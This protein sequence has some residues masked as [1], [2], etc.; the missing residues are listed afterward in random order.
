MKKILVALALFA[1]VL[2]ASAL[3]IDTTVSDHCVLLQNA[4]NTVKGKAVASSTVTVTLG[5]TQIGSGTA[6]GSGN[7]TVTVNPGAASFA[8]RSLVVTDGSDTK[9][10]ADVLVGEVWLGAGQ[11]NAFNPMDPTKMPEY[12]G[13]YDKWKTYFDCPNVR[14]VVHSPD[15]ADSPDA[16]LAWIV[17]KKGNET[18][19][20]K[21]S[22]LALF[23]ARE[24]YLAKNVPVGVAIV[25]RGANA[26]GRFMSPEAYAAAKAAR[27]GGD[28]PWGW[29]SESD[30]SNFHK[31]LTRFDSVAARGCVWSQGEAEAIVGGAYGYRHCLKALIND[32]RS[33]AHRNN[34]NFPVIIS[35]TANY[36]GTYNGDSDQWHGN[37]EGEYRSSTTRW[38]QE[39]AA[40]EMSNVV[41]V[42]AIDLANNATKGY[43]RAEHPTQKPE[44]AARCCK[45]ARS[46][47][48]GENVAYRCPYPT[49]A[50]FN[51][52][53]DKVYVSFPS[54]VSLTMKGSYTHIPFRVKNAGIQ[55]NGSA[56]N[57]TSVKIGSDGHTLEI[58]FSGLT[59]NASEGNNAVAYCNVSGT[60]DTTPLYEQIIYDQN[61]FPL[62]PFELTIANS[63]TESKDGT[64]KRTAKFSS[65]L[66]TQTKN[67]VISK[68]GSG[69][70]PGG[71]T[72]S[73]KANGYEYVQL[74]ANGPAFAK[75]NVG[76]TSETE[77]GLM[78]S[79][80][81][82]VGTVK[83]KT[84]SFDDGCPT[85]GKS[86]AQLKSSDIIDS[87]A[88]LS[89]SYDAANVKMGGDWRMPTKAEIDALISN[90]N[91]EYVTVNDVRGTRVTGRGAYASASIFLPCCGFYNGGGAWCNEQFWGLYLTSTAESANNKVYVYALQANVPFSTTT[92]NRA[93]GY[94]I[95]GV[96]QGATGSGSGKSGG[97]GGD[98]KPGGDSPVTTHTNKV[99][100][101]KTGSGSSSGTGSAGG[102]KGVQLWANGPYW[103]TMNCGATTPTKAGYYY[104][105][106]TDTVGYSV[107]NGALKGPLV[108]NSSRTLWGNGWR[109]PTTAEAQM[110]RSNC[111]I[112][113]TGT[114]SNGQ[115]YVVV[116]GTTAGYTNKSIVI[117]LA[118]YGNGGNVGN[119]NRW[120]TYGK[121][122]TSNSGIALRLAF[123]STAIELANGGDVGHGNCYTIRMVRDTMP[124]GGGD[125]HAHTWSKPSY[126]WTETSSGWTCT[127]RVTC[128][129][130]SSHTASRT[131]A[132]KL[133]VTKAATESTDGTGTYTARFP[134][135]LSTQTKTVTIPAKGSGSG[136]GET[137]PAVPRDSRYTGVQLWAKGPYWAE[138]NVGAA[139]ASD[140]GLF[141]SWGGTKG[142]VR[143]STAAFDGACPTMDQSVS[144]LQSANIVG[145]DGNLAKAYDA[146]HMT[147]GGSWR[148]PTKTELDGLFDTSRCTISAETVGDVKCLRISGIGDF[149][150]KSIL[151]PCVGFY[152]NDGC[153]GGDQWCGY[154][155]SATP[156]NNTTQACGVQITTSGLFAA[157]PNRN[158][159]YT[160]RAVSTVDPRP[161]R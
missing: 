136:S 4:A 138:V 84:T 79:Y 66:S 88:N 102:H 112:A 25:G 13:A 121:Y 58:A 30:K 54:S 147:M 91:V 101:A 20:K 44:L 105:N 108:K 75:C 122:W 22:P 125:T 93:N 150:D 97:K 3:T 124:S 53:K 51:S 21:I 118:G 35:A 123:T 94:P 2:T 19:M 120:G 65:P 24:L 76:A 36:C 113:S 47:A 74:W 45:A 157:T 15:Y 96:L 117:P 153:Y 133:T 34:A 156:N 71:Q 139:S 128:T 18:Q 10:V 61:G 129:G 140:C 27:G 116:S 29:G 69:E 149:A 144:Q 62:P 11:S 6:D 72:G 90:C 37:Y 92:G 42:H 48:Y 64:G 110:M 41:V 77:Y 158:N 160:V 126:T 81:S 40:Q 135:P 68:S 106:N 100:V 23:F 104:F 14:A 39:M 78:F 115:P 7:Y 43:A 134:S 82:K 9:T 28:L 12:A 152:Q 70:Q 151:L 127:A 155:T 56:V 83:G 103:A 143:G 98:V 32:W 132:A 146:A 119:A 131:V 16:E 17:C 57:P 80:G 95:R 154:Y 148:M 161:A 99:T 60:S 141:Y 1:E 50:Y 145:S 26:I 46:V 114:D 109:M 86:I 142:T 33:S 67:V 55:A 52:T 107:K 8:S 87:N 5:G 111:K 63:A 130:D 31:W 49:Q 89:M 85:A 159:G 59:L 137:A 73:G 38:E